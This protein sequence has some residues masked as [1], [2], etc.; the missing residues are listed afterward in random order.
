MSDELRIEGF[1]F[2]ETE[3]TETT[4]PETDVPA[5]QSEDAPVIEGVNSI[6]A[7]PIDQTP[8]GTLD[9]YADIVYCIDLT[10]S[11]RPIIQKVKETA[12][13]LHEDLQNVMMTKYQ[14][15]IKQ[16]RIRV[17]G[18]RDIYCDGA[19]AFET[20]DF[21]YLPDQTAEFQNF[22]DK[23]EAKGGG[24]IP[25]NSLEALAMAMQS[26]WCTTI[27]NSVRK[28]HIVVLFTDASAHPL[29]KAAS[30]TG[31]NYPANMPKSYSELIDWWSGQ[32]SLNSGVSV[33]MD[34]VAKRLALYA[35]EG[36]APWT[37][38][39]EDFDSCLVNFIQ[40]ANGG[41]DIETEDLLKIL[42]ETMA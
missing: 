25:E 3:S 10:A 12:R 32:G 27:D 14:R 30:Y 11:M 28:R 41:R 39:S 17:V 6:E 4:L 8:I 9:V 1:D 18:F 42:G 37:D 40:S 19:Y 36:S 29:E 34:P 23:L 22:V 13:T 20:S 2:F 15:I 26:D 38:L 21:F 24:D 5:M 16:L 7:A 33:N 31:S 35:P